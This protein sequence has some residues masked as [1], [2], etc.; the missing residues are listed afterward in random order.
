MAHRKRK[1]AA[2]LLRDMVDMSVELAEGYYA[3]EY[4]RLN[5]LWYAGNGSIGSWLGFHFGSGSRIDF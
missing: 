2:W 3:P 5:R 4:E 1:L